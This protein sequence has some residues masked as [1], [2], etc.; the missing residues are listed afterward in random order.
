MRFFIIF[1]LSALIFG[2]PIV[3]SQD[4]SVQG[5]CGDGICDPGESCPSCGDCNPP[6]YGSSCNCGA[7]GCGGTIQCS[8][9][10]S[11]GDPT[12]PGYGSSCNCGAC[13]CG[14][15]ITCSG[16]CSG[17]NPA[18]SNYGQPCN[19]A[20]C[21]CGGTIQCNGAC[22]GPTPSCY[23]DIGLRVYDGAAIRRIAAE[24]SGTLT[25]PL[26]ISKGGITYGIVLVDPS[27]PSASKTRIQT[28]AGTKAL[29]KLD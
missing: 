9:A 22:S 23:S 26:R 8:G 15:I 29:R 2:I 6:S 24:P 3:Y 28:T 4:C 17:S 25:S 5:H 20:P 19:C 12:P 13:G 21:G 10:C 14:G 11:G 27:D 16:S 1:I 7:C 18:P